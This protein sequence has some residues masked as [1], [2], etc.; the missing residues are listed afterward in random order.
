MDR[1]K[2]PALW[3]AVVMGTKKMVP[4]MAMVVVV[5]EAMG[6]VPR[7]TK[8][9]FVGRVKVSMIGGAMLVLAGLWCGY[10][11]TA[12]ASV[13]PAVKPSVRIFPEKVISGDT[14]GRRYFLEV[15][16][17]LSW[18]PPV[19]LT[20]QQ[21]GYEK[22]SLWARYRTASFSL[23]LYYSV[24]MGFID[25]GQGWE[26][27][28]NHLKVYLEN[29]SPEVERFSVSHGYN[30][31]LVNRLFRRRALDWRVGVGVVVAHPESVVRGR[32][33][34]ERGGLFN[35]GYYLAGPVLLGGISRRLVVSSWFTLH[36]SGSVTAALARV[37]VSEGH[38]TV[39]VAALQLQV[40][41]GITLPALKQ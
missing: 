34:D 13:N 31:L 40:A 23:P 22:I 20:I 12:A 14:S 1:K 32:R 21:E 4:I 39:P 5:G 27:E 29:T 33:Q 7:M 9:V 16:P 2:I 10:C 11:G 26:A 15:A 6:L 8:M 17:G 24:R 28:M 38:A 18:V 35:N 25:G 37:K 41:P 30:Q 3:G 19:P 36:F